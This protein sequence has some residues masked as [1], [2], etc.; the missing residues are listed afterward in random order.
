MISLA[1]ANFMLSEAAE[2]GWV[3]GTAENYYNEGVK[4]SFNYL[5]NS[6][7]YDISTYL[8]QENVKY[9]AATNKIERIIQQ[10]WLALAGINNIRAWNDFRRLGYPKFPNSVAA[11]DRN[12]YPLRFMYPET[13][14]NTNEKVVLAQGDNGV[15]TAKVWWQVR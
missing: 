9:A 15:L 3:D 10:K 14:I 12:T 2:R 11:V 5:F 8:G 4:A 13:E 1:E 6:G 7:N